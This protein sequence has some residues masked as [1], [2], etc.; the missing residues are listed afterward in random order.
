MQ[1]HG[2]FQYINHHHHHKEHQDSKGTRVFTWLLT[3]IEKPNQVS[4]H[5]ALL[6]FFLLNFIHFVYKTW[7]LDFIFT[8]DYIFFSYPYFLSPTIFPV[9]GYMYFCKLPYHSYEIMQNKKYKR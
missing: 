2:K 7:I 8:F 6:R 3:D 1:V 4:F 5:P 9:L